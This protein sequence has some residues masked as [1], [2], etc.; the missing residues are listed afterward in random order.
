MGYLSSHWY[1]K[2]SLQKTYREPR[3][4]MA[5]GAPVTRGRRRPRCPWGTRAAPGWRPAAG[6]TRLRS[7]GFLPAGL[8]LL[9]WGW[10]TRRPFTKKTSPVSWQTPNIYLLIVY[11]FIVNAGPR[12]TALLSAINLAACDDLITDRKKQNKIPPPPKK[13]PPNFQV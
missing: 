12:I 7:T 3:S 9:L 4:K 2:F 8:L 10:D 11:I 13:T 1:K 6:R 5:A